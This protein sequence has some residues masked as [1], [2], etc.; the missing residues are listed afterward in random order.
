ME[1]QSYLVADDIIVGEG[2]ALDVPTAGAFVRIVSGAIDSFVTVVLMVALLY[3]FSEYIFFSNEAIARIVSILLV[4]SVF[5]AMPTLI[6]TFSHGKSLGKLIM[7]I[8]VVRTDHG[9]ISF[10]HAFTRAMV[11]FFETWITAGVLSTCAVLLTKQGRRFGDLAA[12]TLVVKERIPLQKHT[13]LIMPPGME[14]WAAK[15]DIGS[16]PTSLALSARQFLLRADK[17]SPQARAEV[18]R[19]LA[20][21]LQDFVY[22]LPDPIPH[23]EIFIATVLAERSRRAIKRNEVNAKISKALLRQD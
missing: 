2:V 19:R 3:S 11:G 12:G 15:T 22:P 7:G 9:V 8:R 17:L 14:Q 10:R 23:P 13:A 18:G 21:Q 6:E 4:V 5:I 20:A 1:N 16:I